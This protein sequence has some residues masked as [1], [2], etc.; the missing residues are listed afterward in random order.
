MVRVGHAVFQLWPDQA[1][2][3]KHHNV[4]QL[5]VGQLWLVMQCHERR[6]ILEHADT[7]RLFG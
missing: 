5:T 3:I 4:G 6:S 2:P 1:C 7:T